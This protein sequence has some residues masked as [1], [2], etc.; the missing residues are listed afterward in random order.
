[1]K[2]AAATAR[3]P[4]ARRT[5][6]VPRL[7]AIVP[8]T[9]VSL[10]CTLRDEEGELLDP[11]DDGAFDYVHGYGMLVPGLETALTGL[12]AGDRREILVPPTSGYGEHDPDLVIEV[13][14]ADLPRPDQVA[15]G[16]EVEA[17]F[18]DGATQTMRVVEV[19]PDSVVVDANHPLAGSTLRYFVHVLRV[20]R[21]TEA[22]IEQAAR[23]Q[24]EAEELA[25][26]EGE[27]A[28]GCG[29]GCS[30]EHA[31]AGE[32]LITL[33]RGKGAPN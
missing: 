32:Q 2:R 29:A 27:A 13:E 7:L 23:E 8:N 20:R 9:F 25:E 24:D 4:A 18:P 21:A 22:E 33:G 16:D 1:L 19:R 5:P 10:E 3:G 30:H 31:P 14:R 6:R 11:H 15:E 26:A 17:E 12:Q 28:G